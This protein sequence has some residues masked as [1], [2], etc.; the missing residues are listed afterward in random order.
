MVAALDLTADIGGVILNKT[1][2]CPPPEPLATAGN[3][4]NSSI[5]PAWARW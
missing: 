1:R 3:S 5:R 4:W 2:S